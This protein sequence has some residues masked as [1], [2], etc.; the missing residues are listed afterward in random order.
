[1]AEIVFLVEIGTDPATIQDALTTRTGIISW[2]TTSAQVPKEPGET[3][4]VAFPEAPVPF[5][6][7][8]DQVDPERVAWTSVGDF[9]PHWQG[10][11]VVWNL[12]A[13]PDG[14]G[15]MLFFEHRGFAAADQALGHTAMT[16]AQLMMRLQAYAESGRADPLFVV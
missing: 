3:I 15:T 6:L 16:W 10:T 14:S 7:R 11:E 13:K 2:W 12:A 1:M 9:P 5:T 4:A 8:I